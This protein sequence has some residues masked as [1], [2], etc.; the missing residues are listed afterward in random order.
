[1]VFVTGSFT[2]VGNGAALSYAARYSNGNWTDFLIGSNY[3]PTVLA[4]HGDILF[5]A[6]GSM[7]HYMPYNIPLPLLAMN[8]TS[9]EAI[10]FPSLPLMLNSA[11]VDIN[12]ITVDENF[13]YVGGNLETTLPDGSKANNG[14][15]FPFL[16]LIFIFIS[17]DPVKC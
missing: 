17:L 7:D 9:G 3:V 4:V 5:Y 11:I 8:V 12:A 15:S 2:E 1:M 14:L 13:V 10:T 6:Y 16:L